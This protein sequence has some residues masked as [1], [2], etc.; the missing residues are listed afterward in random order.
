M[1]DDTELA[2]HK[3]PMDA[4]V[5]SVPPTIRPPPLAMGVD[6]NLED[7]FLG[8]AAAKATTLSKTIALM[9]RMRIY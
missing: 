4:R 8:A 9:V 6:R 7:S 3:L 2:K 1:H 5:A